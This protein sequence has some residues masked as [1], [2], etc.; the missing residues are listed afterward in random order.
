MR[1]TFVI[2]MRPVRLDEDGVSRRK[3]EA[4]TSGRKWVEKQQQRR[5]AQKTPEDKI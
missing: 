3:T 5:N 4:R 2:K 1:T